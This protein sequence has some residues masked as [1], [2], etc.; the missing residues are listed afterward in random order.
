[1]IVREASRLDCAAVIA[2]W[3]ACDLTR[4]WNDPTADFTRALEGSSSTVLVALAEDRVSGSAMVGFDGHRGWI[5][6]VAVDPQLQRQGLGRRLLDEC[7]RWLLARGCP[8]VELMVR[9]G[10]PAADLYER[11]GWELQPVR[12]YGRWL[13]DKGT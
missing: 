6:Y 10:N 13:E 2:L 7:Q 8:K 11:L 3:R 5:Y 12:V 9:D 1:M 4:P